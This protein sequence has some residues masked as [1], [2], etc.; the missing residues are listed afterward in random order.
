MLKIPN[1]LS[2][3]RLLMA[4]VLVALALSEFRTPFIIF[5]CISFVTDALDGP[6]ARA[7][8]LRTGL[9]SRL[10]SIADTAN[11]VAALV[12]IFQFEY[13]SLKPHIAMLCAFLAVLLVATLMPLMKYKKIPS[14]HLYSSKLNALFL[15]LFV[16]YFLTFGFHSWYYYFVL[17]FGILAFVE[18]IVVALVLKEPIN[19]AKG[20]YWILNKKNAR[21]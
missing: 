14:F 3:Y 2:I 8:N 19:D 7:W 13:Q 4:P 11:Y 10:D 16:I 9:G 6:I 5:L 15:A 18:I 12:G 20:L 1:L 17:G 21:H